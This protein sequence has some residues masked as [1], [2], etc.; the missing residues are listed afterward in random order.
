MFIRFG[1]GLVN[2]ERMQLHPRGDVE[3]SMPAYFSEVLLCN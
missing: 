3:K 2:D 1:T